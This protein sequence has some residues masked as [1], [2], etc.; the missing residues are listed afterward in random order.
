MD[1]A[2]QEQ[3]EG[4]LTLEARAGDEPIVIHERRPRHPW[5]IECPAC[6]FVFQRTKVAIARSWAK[7]HNDKVHDGR[8]EIIDHTL[9]QTAANP[10]DW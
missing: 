6:D 5:E 7:E 10:L 1:D 9:K 8:L 3:S 2:A 4:T